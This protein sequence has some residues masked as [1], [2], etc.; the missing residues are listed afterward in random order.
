MNYVPCWQPVVKNRSSLSFG[1]LGLCNLIFGTAAASGKIIQ[2]NDWTDWKIMEF[3][4]PSSC[5]IVVWLGW[6]GCYPTQT[7]QSKRWAICLEELRVFLQICSISGCWL[8][9][10]VC[11]PIKVALCCFIGFWLQE[12]MLAILGKN[13]SGLW[14]SLVK[15][16]PFFEQGFQLLLVGEEDAMSF[17][18]AND[19]LLGLKNAGAARVKVENSTQWAPEFTIFYLEMEWRT[20]V[21]KRVFP[22]WYDT[23]HFAC[24]CHLHHRKE[25]RKKRMLQTIE[26]WLAAAL[27]CTTQ[28]QK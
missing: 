22:A 14:P 6:Y 7:F 1:T 3:F 13:V 12:M 16:H 10:T 5:P 21:F 25:A 26:K 27:Q 11:T 20:I 24:K 4:L 8:D 2:N 19:P 23:M 18:G 28:L 9:E 17:S 15:K